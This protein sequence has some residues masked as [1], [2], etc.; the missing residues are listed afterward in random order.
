ML[1][2]FYL[3]LLVLTTNEFDNYLIKQKYIYIHIHTHTHTQSC[4]LF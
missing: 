2:F 3:E 1:N 4:A